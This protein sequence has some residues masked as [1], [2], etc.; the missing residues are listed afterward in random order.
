MDRMK[1]SYILE[2]DAGGSSHDI[3]F[4]TKDQTISLRNLPD[5]TDTK[6]LRALLHRID[7]MAKIIA[8][9]CIV[10][11]G[12]AASLCLWYTVNV[13]KAL[14]GF[15]L[16][17]TCLAV[18]VFGFTYAHASV[19]AA[20]YVVRRE[21]LS[22]K[23]CDLNRTNYL[24]LFHKFTEKLDMASNNAVSKFVTHMYWLAAQSDSIWELLSR[25]ADDKVTFMQLE[26][27]PGHSPE[28]I[29]SYRYIDAEGDILNNCI[30]INCSICENMY[31]KAGLNVLDFSDMTFRLGKK[32]DD[33]DGKA[34][35]DSDGPWE[36]LKP[37]LFMG[38]YNALKDFLGYDFDPEEDKDTTENRLEQA[39][40]Q[41][42]DEEFGK[43]LE[44]YGIE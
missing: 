30:C 8:V 37:E 3:R 29:I 24:A 5:K 22:G 13:S 1:N 16:G 41:M 6:Y 19:I 32:W 17:L 25:I 12:A 35:S 9:S 33:A 14:G 21:P 31:I 28:A 42:P 18:T 26:L 44:K 38:G 27:T 36:R 4:K 7:V 43:F 23:T 10:L 39:Y 40:M 34:G 20:R 15:E 2:P 11:I